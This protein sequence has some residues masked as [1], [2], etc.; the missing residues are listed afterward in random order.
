MKQLKQLT[1]SLSTSFTKD[2]GFPVID[3]TDMSA[4]RNISKYLN[5]LLKK[6]KTGFP[7]EKEKVLIFIEATTFRGKE[8][9]KIIKCG[10]LQK[11]AGGRYKTAKIVQLFKNNCCNC[12]HERYFILSDEGIGYTASFGNSFLTDNLFFDTTL[13]VNY[14]PTA[15]REEFEIDIVTSSRKLRL[16]AADTPGMYD[17]LSGIVDSINNSRYCK[18]NRFHSFCPVTRSN[19]AKWYINGV[20]YYADLADEVERAESKIFITDWWLSPQIYLKRPIPVTATGLDTFWRLDQ[21][22]LRAAQRGVMIHVLLYKEFDHALPNDS[23]Y[24]RK[25]LMDLHQNIEVLRHPGDLIFLWS[26]HEK[27]CVIDNA[28][29]FMGGLDLC[30]GRWDSENY[31][32]SDPGV[33]GKTCYF[34]GQDYSNV[35][36][37]DFSGVSDYDRSLISKKD[38]PRMPWRDIAVCI[39]GQCVKDS[40]RHFIQYWNFAKEDLSNDKGRLAKGI[41]LKKAPGERTLQDTNSLKTRSTASTALTKSDCSNLDKKKRFSERV[42]SVIFDDEDKLQEAREAKTAEFMASTCSNTDIEVEDHV[43]MISA[44]GKA[45]FANAVATMNL[46][47]R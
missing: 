47:N 39:R 37:K 46:D 1:S 5:K 9:G 43:H 10:P 21:V 40:A 42:Q 28:V 36:I 3:E 23:A 8:I 7:K 2:I 6:S 16:L 25:T 12:W 34:P 26:H 13:R 35:R 20:D 17:W 32:L 44:V 27:M 38:N 31:S 22:L 14:G 33:E 30:F 18:L 19:Y 45:K 4:T 15:E 41:K 24:S 11:K 29:T